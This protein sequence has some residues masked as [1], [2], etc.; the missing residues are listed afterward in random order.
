MKR[1]ST[2]NREKLI[3]RLICDDLCGIKSNPT[4]IEDSMLR[5]GLVGYD[6]MPDDVLLELAGDKS[7]EC[8][9][10]EVLENDE[11]VNDYLVQWEINVSAPT[12]KDAAVRARYY[13]R[14]DS[15][16][17]VFDIFDDAGN[18]TRVDLISEVT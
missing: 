17:T 2:I 16:A 7:L 15:S 3:D 13:Q 4:V 6:T 14:P 11:P 18:T 9:D 5:F 8:A 10:I 1:L 12:P